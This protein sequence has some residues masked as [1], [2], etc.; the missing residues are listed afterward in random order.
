MEITCSKSAD[1][2]CGRKLGVPRLCV[3]VIPVN[4]KKIYELRI[5]YRDPNFVIPNGVENFQGLTHIHEVCCVIEVQECF[6]KF[7]GLLRSA[8]TIEESVKV[9]NEH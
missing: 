4:C 7:C 8:S 3:R 9:R 6:T 1:K 2:L 5:S